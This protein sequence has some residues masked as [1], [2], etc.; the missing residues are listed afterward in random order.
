MS[1]SQLSLS[2]VCLCLCEELRLC[3]YYSA[4]SSVLLI[5]LVWRRVRLREEEENEIVRGV[6]RKECERGIEGERVGGG[7]GVGDLSIRFMRSF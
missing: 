1:F 4:L 2:P 3:P 7:E 5:T 6:E